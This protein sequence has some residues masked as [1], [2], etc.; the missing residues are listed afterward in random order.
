MISDSL[1]YFVFFIASLLFLIKSADF[2]VRYSSRVAQYFRLSKYTIG[3]LLVAVISILPETFIAVTSAFEGVPSFGLGTLFGGNVADLTI[4]FALMVLFAGRS[5]H[6]ESQIIKNRFSYIALLAMPILFGL[7]GYY[8]RWE[9]LALI[10]LGILFFLFILRQGAL[11]TD[12]V[13]DRFSISNT[14][15]LL[16][17]LAALLVSSYLTVDYGVQFAESLFISPLLVGIFVVGLGTTL[18]ELLFSVR[19]VKNKSDDLALGDVLGTVIADAT[20]VVGLIAVIQPFSFPRHIVFITGLFM[21]VASI[22]LLSFMKSGRKITR[23]EAL[24]L[25]LFYAIFIAAE[26]VVG[27]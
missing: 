10:V 27:G 16:V 3:F 7:N 26:L 2:T 5:L 14:A 11:K 19:A 13:K 6:A 22:M 23:N 24:L 9:G 25:L 21:F 1:S 8:S 12:E 17:S 20:I 18:P 4:V 15:L